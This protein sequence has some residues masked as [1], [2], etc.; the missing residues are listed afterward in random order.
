MKYKGQPIPLAG[1]TVIPVPV[2]LLQILNEKKLPMSTLRSFSDLRRILTELDLKNY[3]VHVYCGS[4]LTST[5]RLKDHGLLKALLETAAQQN[6]HCVVSGVDSSFGLFALDHPLIAESVIAPKDKLL[7]IQPDSVFDP[8][9]FVIDDEE[10][11]AAPLE[12]A[13]VMGLVLNEI[14]NELKEDYIESERASICINLLSKY[15]GAK[16]LTLT[17]LTAHWIGSNLLTKSAAAL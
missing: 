9:L 6:P 4:N 3:L 1:L 12:G 14:P 10:F 7:G 2:W 16:A 5:E 15:Y 17:P 11:M 13:L 8:V